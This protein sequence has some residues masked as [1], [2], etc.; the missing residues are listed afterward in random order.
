MKLVM[1]GTF[2]FIKQYGRA[3]GQL[4]MAIKFLCDLERKLAIFITAKVSKIY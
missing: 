2:L 4:E 3:R 1:T